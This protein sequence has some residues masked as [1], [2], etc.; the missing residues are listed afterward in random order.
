MVFEIENDADDLNLGGTAQVTIK[1]KNITDVLSIPRQA[2]SQKEGKPAVYRKKGNGWEAQNVLVKYLTESRAII[3]GLEEGSEVALVN[4]DLQKSRSAANSGP[5][6]SI[7]GG[8]D[9]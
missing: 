2:L 8:T 5:L 3:D 9:R 6:T 1:G 7:L 4:P